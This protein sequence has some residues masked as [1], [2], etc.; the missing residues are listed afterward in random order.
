M[1]DLSDRHG[2]RTFADTPISDPPVLDGVM[3]VE[4]DFYRH[5]KG[6]LYRVKGLCTVEGTL[7]VGV[8]YQ[9]VDPLARQDVWMRP[10]PDFQGPVRAG[11]VARF[12]RLRTPV[13]AALREYLGPEVLPASVL[14]SVLARYDEPWR[15]FH[16]RRRVYDLFEKAK[17]HNVVLSLEQALALLFLDAVY[18]PGAPE[19]QNERQSALLMQA[20]KSQVLAPAVN[21]GQVA[22]IIEDSATR[23]PSSELSK[24]ILDLADSELGEDPVHFCAFDELVWLENRHLLDAEDAR[25]DFDT[26][27]L[28]FLLSQAERGPL[29]C[30]ALVGLENAARNNLEGLRQAWVQKYSATRA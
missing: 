20:F 21:W 24:P 6:G 15:Y 18:V 28:R 9:A 13:E 27:R 10:L 2:S 17:A 4:G 7:E 5:Y 23:V 11:S 22:R 19:G 1:L 26:R 16:T 12:S 30:D 8:L 25:K 29:Y 3:P 14:E